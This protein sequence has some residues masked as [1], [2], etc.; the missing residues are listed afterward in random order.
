MIDALKQ[1]ERSKGEDERAHPLVGAVLVDGGSVHRA[2]RGRRGRGD[3][4]E[5]GLL[6][7]TSANKKDG[8]A[9]LYTTLEP[10]TTRRHPK[11]ACADRIVEHRRIKHVCIGMLDPNPS[12]TGKGL[13]RLRDAGIAVSLFDPDLMERAEKMNRT[14]ARQYRPL[15]E[16]LRAKTL[17]V[18]M[19]VRSLDDWYLVVNTIYL[20]RNFD[21]STSGVFAHLVEI[22]GGLGVLAN[23]K[24]PPL[25]PSEYVAKAL[26]WWMALAGKVGVRNLSEMLWAKYPGVC[27]YCELET[28]SQIECASKKGK[29]KPNWPKLEQIGKR[30]KRPGTLMEWQRMFNVIYPVGRG[31]DYSVTVASL[32]E[33]IGELSEA[34]RAKDLRPGYFLS[35]AADVFAWLMHLQNVVDTKGKTSKEKLG[36]ALP[37]A[38]AGAYPD[39]CSRCQGQLCS[40]P[41]IPR[42]TLGRIAHEQPDGAALQLSRAEALRKFGLE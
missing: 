35:E 32:L 11:L 23:G 39:R 19:A 1:A 41:P 14:F 38:F 2:H 33:E 3:H 34:I 17:P 21:K 16:A 28:H 27:P 12:I 29:D 7:K 13:L 26:A 30:N 10:C 25:E 24:E 22:L 18:D 20:N 8:D 15:T 6:E 40:C 37:A 5:Y 36:E 9:I 42:D 4:A 31:E